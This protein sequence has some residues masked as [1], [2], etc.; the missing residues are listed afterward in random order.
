MT[1]MERGTERRCRSRQGR[2]VSGF[3]VQ[4]GAMQC[5]EDLDITSGVRAQYWQGVD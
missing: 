2:S 5:A 4:C 1:D 3:A